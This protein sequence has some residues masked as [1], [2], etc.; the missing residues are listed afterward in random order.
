M[1]IYSF[2]LLSSQSVEKLHRRSE[3]DSIVRSLILKIQ[4]TFNRKKIVLAHL[5][6]NGVHL[7]CRTI[8]RST[9]ITDPPTSME[10]FHHKCEVTES[11]RL[12]LALDW[13]LSFWNVLEI[14]KNRDMVTWHAFVWHCNEWGNISLRW[15][16]GWIF[17]FK[18]I[19]FILAHFWCKDVV[20]TINKVN[21]IISEIRCFNTP[22]N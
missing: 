13:L 1:R 20:K 19:F 10:L 8:S 5:A 22:R 7:F 6:R 11:V 14:T 16:F 21:S 2:F 18:A 9:I 3:T 15:H 17:L 12:I 4:L